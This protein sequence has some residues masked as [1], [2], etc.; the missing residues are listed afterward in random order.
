MG[1]LVSVVEHLQRWG[2]IYLLEMTGDGA[3]CDLPL[4]PEAV[5]SIH[6]VKASKPVLHD[7][8]PSFQDNLL[9]TMAVDAHD[10]RD[11]V[12]AIGSMSYGSLTEN[13]FPNY[14]LSHD[15]VLSIS[16]RLVTF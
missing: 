8:Q 5:G 12:F 11:K 2:F 16:M 9:L 1:D 10:P 7:D 15:D 6:R 14:E 13:L 3:P 4:Y